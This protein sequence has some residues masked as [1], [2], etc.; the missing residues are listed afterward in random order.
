M[1][2]PNI[3][4]SY[5]QPTQFLSPNTNQTVTAFGSTAGHPASVA[6]FAPTGAHPAT[7]V[8]QQVVYLQH[9]HPNSIKTIIQTPIPIIN[10]V[11]IGS[12]RQSEQPD[13]EREEKLKINIEML[14]KEYEKLYNLYD[15]LRKRP[16]SAE[17]KEPKS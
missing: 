5:R 12:A 14:Q 16:Q 1:G 7:A 4:I 15:N 13:R 11:I 3:K 2:S 6:A 8:P 9:P 17:Q 10:P